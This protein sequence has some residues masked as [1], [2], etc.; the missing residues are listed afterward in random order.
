MA[1]I[2]TTMSEN[3]FSLHA[4][5]K[6]NLRLKVTGRRADGYHL[7]SMV[8]TSVSL[9]DELLVR[10]NNSGA[11]SL[12]IDGVVESALKR[13]LMNP[14]KNLVGRAVSG[15]CRNFDLK[16]GAS[17]VLRK[18]I[19]SQAGLGGGS[20]DAASLLMLLYSL[21]KEEIKRTQK[22]SDEEMW[23][24][25]Y[26]LALNLGADVP[27]LLRGGLAYVRGVG[28]VVQELPGERVS[29]VQCILVHPA[30]KL[31]TPRIFARYRELRSE[32]EGDEKV[33]EL[34]GREKIEISDL[35]PLV[36]N[37]LRD[38]IFLEAPRV[39][40]TFDS[41]SEVS[42]VVVGVTGS[43]SALFVL[44]K[45]GRGFSREAIDE[46]IGRARVLGAT[47]YQ[48]ELQGVPPLNS[49]REISKI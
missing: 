34:V 16:I 23:H 37:D 6:I 18:R 27:Y 13:E 45:E 25:L 36:D 8:N 31:S 26:R 17:I 9:D 47:S 42:G 39:K 5:A 46:I 1:V 40:S 22:M 11:I 29:G 44:P 41:L 43:G 2:T 19:P 35:L 15:F 28:E 10:I 48:C 20:S 7:L 24:A 21:H 32:F 33:A 12:S 38:P 3:E 14:D 4:L 30:A 49:G